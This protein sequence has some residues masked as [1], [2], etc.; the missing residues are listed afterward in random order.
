MGQNTNPKGIK[1]YFKLNENINIT[2]QISWGEFRAKLKCKFSKSLNTY[3]M[4]KMPYLGTNLKELGGKKKAKF[5]KKAKKRKNN[6]S[7]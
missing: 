6:T 2:N 3:V 4:E 5:S 1:K 7:Q